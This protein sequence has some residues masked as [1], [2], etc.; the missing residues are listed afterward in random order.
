LLRIV[1]FSLVTSFFTLLLSR[2]FVYYFRINLIA[3][4]RKMHYY[5]IYRISVFAV[6]LSVRVGI[7]T[8]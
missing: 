6:V 1:V 4:Y 8:G 7:T 2:T 5:I 3:V